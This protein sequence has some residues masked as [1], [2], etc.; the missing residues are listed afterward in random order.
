MIT[1]SMMRGIGMTSQRTRERLVQRLR[2]K[3]IQ[4]NHVLEVI[5]NT[6]RH[7]F[8]DE[9]LASRAYEDTAL[10]IGYGQTISQPYIVA[11]MTELLLLGGNP[12]KVLEVGTGC[13]YQTAILAQI[14]PRTYSVE[15]IEGLLQQT[16]KRL[17]MLRLNNVR[18]KHSDGSWGWPENAPFD[19]IIV[20]AA[21]PEIP[22]PL[23]EQL[24]VGGRMVIPVGG[25]NGVQKL[26]VIKRTDQAYEQQ[27]Y[28]AVSF[29]PMVGGA[30]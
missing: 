1:D 5:L 18:C 26:L 29:V 11:R 13:G 2:E 19:A 8:M 20:T 10:P 27:E 4:N 12:D 3:G 6:P 9:A 24:A 14:V 7:L 21:P 16:R 17:R 25:Q 30:V 28:E 23:L 22:R 15:R